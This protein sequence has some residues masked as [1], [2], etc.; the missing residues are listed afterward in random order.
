[1]YCD[2]II[3]CSCHSRA[4]PWY[5]HISLTHSLSLSWS[6]L[7][8][9][10][11]SLPPC[12]S[13]FSLRVPARARSLCLLLLILSAGCCMP[14]PGTLHDDACPQSHVSRPPLTLPSHCDRNISSHRLLFFMMCVR[15]CVCARGYINVT[16]HAVFVMLSEKDAVVIFTLTDKNRCTHTHTHAGNC[17]GIRTGIYIARYILTR[18]NTHTHANIRTYPQ[19]H[20]HTRTGA[21][22]HTVRVYIADNTSRHTQMGGSV[23]A[24]RRMHSVLLHWCRLRCAAHGRW[25]VC[26]CACLCDG[27]RAHVGSIGFVWRMRVYACVWSVLC[28]SSAAS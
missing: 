12:L 26:A 23:F 17:I 16:S 28:E 5:I 22:T 3:S 10:P 19:T 14:V 7:A 20:T 11:L 8:Y 9:V 1:M 21:C 13:S 15:V 25:C 6:F 24:A 27:V 18:A 4:L 2:G